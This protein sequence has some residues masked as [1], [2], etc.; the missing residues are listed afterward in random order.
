MLQKSRSY[1]IGLNIELK[2]YVMTN[3]S[4]HWPTARR[5]VNN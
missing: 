3:Y 5:L 2:D 4:K 1:R